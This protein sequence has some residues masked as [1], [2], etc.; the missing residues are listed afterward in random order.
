[1]KKLSIFLAL[2]S[3][4][5]FSCTH[6]NGNKKASSSQSDSETS[7]TTAMRKHLDAVENRDVAALQSTMAPT[8][9]LYFLLDKRP[10]STTSTSFMDFHREWFKDSTWTINFKILHTAI[11]DNLGVAITESMYKE[12][13]RDG[14]PY[15]HKMH[16]SYTQQKIDG[17]WYVI[18]DQASS[19]EK[20][21]D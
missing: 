7:F 13:N 11:D 6:Q 3:V 9:T 20:S 15:Y 19:I 14:K 12:P 18:M 1:M 2:I 16:V 5:M 4:L 8:G 17:Q 21:T 10:L